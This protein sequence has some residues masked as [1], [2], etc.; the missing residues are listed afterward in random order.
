LRGDAPRFLRA[1]VGVLGVLMLVAIR[2]LLRPAAPDH[3]TPTIEEVDRAHA[4]VEDD[5][6]SQSNLAL[7]GD[8]PFLFS[9]NGR[10]FIMYGVEIVHDPAPILPELRAISDSWLSEKKA[11]E[12]GFSLGFFAEDYVRRFPVAVVR[13]EGR[14]VAFSNIWTS[15]QNE[16]LSVDLMRHALD[17]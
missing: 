9:E 12:K 17:A 8:K 5:A 13:R 10:A 11:R 14:I 4:I 3:H 16:E 2:R 6:N 15:A 1:S 7:L